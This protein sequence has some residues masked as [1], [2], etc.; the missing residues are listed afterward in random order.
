MI[1]SELSYTLGLAGKWPGPG[2][3]H[4]AY[5][6][7]Y[8]EKAVVEWERMPD[9]VLPTLLV[10]P[11]EREQIHDELVDFA[12]GQHLLRR[13]LDGHRDEADVAVGRLCVRVAAP[14][15]FVGAGSLQC[16]ADWGVRWPGQV[17]AVGT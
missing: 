3:E 1:D 8:L 6:Y 15:R 7:I 10:L 14:V 11:I 12:Q 5:T 16:W 9:R 4:A 2:G 17:S 13:V